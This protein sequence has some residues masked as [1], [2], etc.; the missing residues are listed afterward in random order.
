MLRR[1]ASTL[2][3]AVT[4]LENRLERDFDFAEKVEKLKRDLQEV[5]IFKA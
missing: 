3:C 2:T 1:N 4:R 5:Q